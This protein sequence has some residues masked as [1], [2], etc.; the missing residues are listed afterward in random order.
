MEQ[1]ARHSRSTGCARERCVPRGAGGRADSRFRGRHHEAPHPRSGSLSG[2]RRRRECPCSP[3]ARAAGERRCSR[4]KDHARVLLRLGWLGA[5]MDTLSTPEVVA[6]CSRPSPRPVTHPTSPRRR[7]QRLRDCSE[8]AATTWS[9][10][11]HAS[12]AVAAGGQ[13]E[14]NLMFPSPSGELGTATFFSGRGFDEQLFE[15]AIERESVP[16]RVAEPYQSP[17]LQFALGL[18]YTGQLSRARAALG[19]AVA[20]VRRPGAGSFHR[21]L[22]PPSDR[23]RGQSRKPRASRDPRG[24]VRSPRPA[25]PGRAQRGVVPERAR[26]DAAWPGRGGPSHPALGRRPLPLDRVD[27]LA[28]ASALGPRSPRARARQSRGGPRSPRAAPRDAPRDRAWRLP[29]SP[30]TPG[31]DPRRWSR[32]AS[33]MAQ[34]SSQTSSRRTPI[35]STVR[36]GERPRPCSR[37]LIASA[38]G[39]NDTALELADLALVEHNRLDWPLERGRTLLVRGC[40]LEAPRPPSRCRSDPRRGAVA[41]C[42]DRQPP[43]EAR[44]EAEARRLGG[45]RR[46]G[47]LTATETRVA[48]LAAQGLRN[49]ENPPRAST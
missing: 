16:S 36:G 41:L 24:R 32:S 11:R 44:A 46:T 2:S 14:A 7:T 30:R 21:W 40:I 23:A 43:R 10:H 22:H 39:A 15:H 6:P 8:T 45:K 19:G 38:R 42:G 20:A 18:L 47:T 4:A 31:C 5:M 33:S 49:T 3:V 1:A 12:L 37:A 27:D 29:C 35:G 17:K 26:G 34:P 28:R 48:E 13:T 9:A 25:T